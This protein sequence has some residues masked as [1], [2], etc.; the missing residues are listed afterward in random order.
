MATGEV[1]VG[2]P[3]PPGPPGQNGLQG[4]PGIKGDR[5]MDG[6]KGEPV[7]IRSCERGAAGWCCRSHRTTLLFWWILTGTGVFQG[8]KG[9]KGDPGPMGL[10]VS[11]QLRFELY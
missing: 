3:G 5:G 2:P 7:S 6:I 11:R 9:A 4:P 8:E 10:P 1:I